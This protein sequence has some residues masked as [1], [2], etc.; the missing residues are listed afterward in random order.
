MEKRFV[1]GRFWSCKAG[2]TLLELLIVVLIIGILVAIA[3]SA[4]NKAVEKSRIVRILPLLS[5]IAQA[6]AVYYLGTGET[7]CDLDKLQVQ[8][9]YVKQRKVADAN[10][11][12]GHRYEYSM[13]DGTYAN[14]IAFQTF[15]PT[16]L[17]TTPLYSIQRY[18]DIQTI[19]GVK[20]Y[21]WCEG[22]EKDGLG[23]R[24]CQSVGKPSTKK[25]GYGT[26]YYV[27]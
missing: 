23:D 25:G 1:I 6:R 7:V 15:E 11:C 9:P 4:Y 8:I 21:G 14:K 5:A 2:F 13:F 26:T 20:G 17:Y 18:N 22:K 24:I 10:T 12:D 19:G 27:F 16:V 3:F